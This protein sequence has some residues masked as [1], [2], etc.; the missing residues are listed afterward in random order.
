MPEGSHFA[1]KVV[2]K[3]LSASGH[4]A[5]WRS[6]CSEWDQTAVFSAS[7]MNQ[8][9]GRSAGVH[10]GGQHLRRPCRTGAKPLRPP[11]PERRRWT[12]RA[13]TGR[14][15]EAQPRRRKGQQSHGITC[16]STRAPRASPGGPKRTSSCKSGAVAPFVACDRT[17]AGSPPP[18]TQHDAPHSVHKRAGRHRHDAERGCEG[19][20]ATT[21]CGAVCKRILIPSHQP[22]SSLHRAPCRYAVTTLE[23]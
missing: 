6:A 11:Q 17:W 8:H 4:P 10:D 19:R 1:K 5:I 3:R 23:A 2:E 21:M 18:Q 12:P 13:A 20:A 15:M 7:I 16:R 14:R 9:D 22:R